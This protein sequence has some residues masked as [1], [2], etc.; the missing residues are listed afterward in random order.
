MKLD[1]INST[2]HLGMLP[3]EAVLEIMQSK[4]TALELVMTG[5]NCPEEIMEKADLVTEM[6]MKKHYFY[7]GVPARRGIEY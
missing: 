1:D 6:M 5:R 3:L 7:K 2:T 4:P